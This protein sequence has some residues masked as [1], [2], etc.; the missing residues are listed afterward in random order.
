MHALDFAQGP[1]YEVIITGD[2]SKVK[3]NLSLLYNSKQLNKV[4]IFKKQKKYDKNSNFLFLNN[5]EFED[6][7]EPLFY[8]CKNYVCDLPTA[9][10]ENVLKNL[11]NN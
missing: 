4:L 10:I 3:K 5:Y 6:D 7:T 8:V 2:E 9:N 11:N 1:S